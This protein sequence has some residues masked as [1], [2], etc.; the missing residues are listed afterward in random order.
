MKAAIDD[1]G[2]CR[3][4]EEVK[5]DVP[6]TIYGKLNL[7]LDFRP[8]FRR[9]VSVQSLNL[10]ALIEKEIFGYGVNQWSG[11]GKP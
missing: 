10:T 4:G 7:T 2:I 11:Y 8:D 9:T 6:R 1:G 3:G 5:V